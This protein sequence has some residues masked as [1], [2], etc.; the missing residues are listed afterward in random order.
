ML[1]CNWY[2][3]D[4]SSSYT[5]CMTYLCTISCW[6]NL[7][8]E[9]A[10][11]HCCEVGDVIEEQLALFRRRSVIGSFARRLLIL[12]HSHAVDWGPGRGHFRR[13][14]CC[15]QFDVVIGWRGRCSERVVSVDS[16]H[17]WTV[18]HHHRHPDSSR[19]RIRHECHSPCDN[20]IVICKLQFSQLASDQNV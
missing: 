16:H 2:L 19:C 9:D 4:A 15:A 10:V 8:I 7:L 1:N 11:R 5:I 13:S 17:H 20:A 14:R 6:T 12:T 18:H 3:L